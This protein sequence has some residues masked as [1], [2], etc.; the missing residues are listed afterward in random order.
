MKSD[1]LLYALLLVQLTDAIRNRDDDQAATI[2]ARLYTAHATVRA[3]V[4]A[5]VS[6]PAL[7]ACDVCACTSK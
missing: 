2:L 6:V 1:E 5:V 7:T 3:V 4:V